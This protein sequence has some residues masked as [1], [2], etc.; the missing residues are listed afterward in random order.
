MR[1]ILPIIL[2][3]TCVS[4]DLIGGT[5]PANSETDAGVNS[6]STPA[7]ADVFASYPEVEPLYVAQA[8][9][10]LNAR[11]SMLETL[12]LVTDDGAKTLGD[13]QITDA[14]VDEFMSRVETMRH[15]SY[16]VAWATYQTAQAVEILQREQTA[17]GTTTT[18]QRLEPVSATLFV[19]GLAATGLALYAGLSDANSEV[20]GYVSEQI[21]TASEQELAV[22]NETMGLAP[23]TSNQ[24][25]QHHFQSQY[26]AG[27]RTAMAQTLKE[28]VGDAALEQNDNRIRVWDFKEPVQRASVKL[29]KT[30]AKTVVSSVR[31]AVPGQ[32]L[33]DRT[34][35]DGNFRTLIQVLEETGTQ[36][37]VL[38]LFLSVYSTATGARVSL[39]DWAESYFWTHTTVRDATG[40]VTIPGHFEAGI[41]DL[42]PEDIDFD[43]LEEFLERAAQEP[44]YYRQEHMDNVLARLA[45]WLSERLEGINVTTS[46]SGTMIEY[47]MTHLRQ[48]PVDENP[49]PLQE[50]EGDHEMT[51]LLPGEGFVA[52]SGPLDH[53]ETV[54][55]TIDDDNNSPNSN[56]QNGDPGA[57][58][59]GD[60]IPDSED[61]CP[62]MPNFY[63]V[64]TDGDGVGNDCDETA[65]PA[66]D[67]DED[68]CVEG[69]DWSRRV[70]ACV[71]PTC[72]TGAMHNA[73]MF[74]CCN[75]W[76]DDTLVNVI[77]P[78]RP[79]YLLN[80]SE[81]DPGG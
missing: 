73:D 31:S 47:P 4:C 17:D 5:A 45:E 74:C 39:E 62:D 65:C 6:T 71:Q 36:R 40:S 29:G 60:T 3:L 35:L 76:D 24:D 10:A 81:P 33:P 43:R 68:G 7:G 67:L 70:A 44:E 34:A 16:K 46:D 20:D 18:R 61:N 75:C 69:M 11:A 23:G 30:A 25:A 14:D 56:S 64:D 52:L 19:A 32:Q 21:K 1:N 72:P 51:V 37:E 9:A 27:E 66:F 15:E 50:F 42:R 63:Q 58:A 22:I 79:G 12:A 2:A 48:A 38:N 53:G 8:E 57:D 78:C 49:V 54:D 59:D 13:G 77:D 26:A 55:L 41:Y 80:C 28:R